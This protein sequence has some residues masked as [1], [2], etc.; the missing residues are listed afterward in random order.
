[1]VPSHEWIQR[2]HAALP[3]LPAQRREHL[4]VMTGQSAD[5]EAVMSVVERG[6]DHYVLAVGHLGGETA[7]ALVYVKEAFA[8]QGPD[9]VIPAIDIAGLTNLEMQGKV[10][11]TQAKSILSDIIANGGGDAAAIA[12]AKGFEALDT[13]A[14]ESVVDQVIVEQA[15]AW[16]KFC[17]GDGKAMGAI[18]GAVMKATQGKADGKLVTALLNQKK[19]LQP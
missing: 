18:V 13:G 9:P 10:T 6:Q 12:A 8:D 14:L 16:A 3:P 17:A 7:R 5:S 4:A 19:A 15:D 2:V 1:V 11:A